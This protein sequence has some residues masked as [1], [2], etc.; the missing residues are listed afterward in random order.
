[1]KTMVSFAIAVLHDPTEQ[2][3]QALSM[4]LDHRV[5][6]HEGQPY[7]LSVGTIC[8]HGDTPEAVSAARAIKQA[9]EQKGIDLC[10]PK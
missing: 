9:L 2:A 7:T 4:A 6:T 3:T 8:V 1:M 10:A 5:T